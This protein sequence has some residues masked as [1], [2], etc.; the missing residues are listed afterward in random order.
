LLLSLK[1]SHDNW[2]SRH[3]RVFVKLIS[4]WSFDPPL[5]G[6]TEINM[7]TCLQTVT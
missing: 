3:G 6:A 1:N 5:P 7:A 4:D 2:L